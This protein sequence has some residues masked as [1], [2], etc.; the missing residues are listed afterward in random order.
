M[1]KCKILCT[2]HS[3]GWTGLI[4]Y[5]PLVTCLVPDG[6]GQWG[7]C[8][9]WVYGGWK[10][11]ENHT[12]YSKNPL[13][14]ILLI[15]LSSSLLLGTQILGLKCEK[16]YRGIQMSVL[17]P[18]APTGLTPCWRS[19]YTSPAQMSHLLKLNKTTFTLPWN[20]ISFK[21]E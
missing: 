14:M 2:P 15:F 7:G 19:C 16:L 12:S 10:A 1:L 4:Y 5:E 11:V 20:E 13:F 3:V 18:G 17:D 8:K 6:R 21:Q 9:I